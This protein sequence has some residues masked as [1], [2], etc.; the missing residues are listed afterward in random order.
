[1]Q[2]EVALSFHELKPDMSRETLV[3]EVVA[4]E[5]ATRALLDRAAR[6]TWD[7]QEKALF[8]RLAKREEESLRELAQEQDRLD[9]EAFVQRAIGC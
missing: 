5:Q 9:A 1:M 6:L 4:A 3:G 8:E 7:P 2:A